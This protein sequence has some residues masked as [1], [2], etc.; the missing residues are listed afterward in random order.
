MVKD[1][2][3]TAGDARG[4]FDPGSE[5]SPGEGMATHSIFT[6]IHGQKSP[7][8]L[9]SMGSKSRTQ[10]SSLAHTYIMAIKDIPE[11]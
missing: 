6:P 1:L 10:L 11:S 8:R 7:G 3:A 9:W 2:L 5:D 4:R